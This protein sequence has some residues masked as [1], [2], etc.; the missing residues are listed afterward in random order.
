MTGLV[1]PDVDNAAY[2]SGFACLVGR[3]NAGKSTLINRMVGTKIVITSARPQ[4]TR[5]VVR[6]VVSREDAQIIVVDT[7]G[8][9]RP[10][11]L[12]GERLNDL[13]RSTWTEVDIVGF[14]L[15]ANEE[16]G[17]GD[18]KLAAEISSIQRGPVVIIV[19]KIDIATPDQVARRLADASELADQ[20][21]LD[22][23]AFI[24]VSAVTGD[25]VETLM[26][27]ISAA[28]P[29]G[30][31]LFPADQQTDE[32][33]ESLVAELIR[34]A[35]LADVKE[36]LPHSIAVTVDE[37]GMREGRPEDKPMLD[38]FATIH[39]ERDSQKPIII[40]KKGAH[41]KKIGTQSRGNIETLL[42]IPVYLNLH[43]RVAKEWQ[44]DPKQLGRLG[45]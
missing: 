22:V 44:R 32:T 40:G 14:C 41:L 39:V 15:A 3:P 29:L 43:V 37:M 25:N 16:T 20:V 34:E 38:I 10:R 6:G 8:L 4:T 31:P 19:T 1:S 42:S 11:T 35:A 2:R 45:F 13:V 17:P 30:P 7:P 28:L 5:R 12:L 27:V 26:D 24:P 33:E 23:A 18:R 36:E 21:E 9:H